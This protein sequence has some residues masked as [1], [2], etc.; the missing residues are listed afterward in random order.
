ML[1]RYQSELESCDS[2][3]LEPVED[4]TQA[5]IVYL[6]DTYIGRVFKSI[7]LPRWL[8]S[9]EDDGR[10]SSPSDAAFVLVEQWETRSQCRGNGLEALPF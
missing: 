2:I 6:N 9:G 5:Y 8:I 10:Y 7:C 3:Y 4:I 1:Q